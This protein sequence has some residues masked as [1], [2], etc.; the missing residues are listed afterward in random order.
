[1]PIP[2]D[3]SQISFS[4]VIEE[5]CPV[6]WE[7]FVEFSSGGALDVASDIGEEEALQVLY[8]YNDRLMLEFNAAQ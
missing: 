1:M 8:D 3:H 5:R 7:E 4:E 2:D 6:T